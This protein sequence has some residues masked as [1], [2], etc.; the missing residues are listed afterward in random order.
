MP[1]QDHPDARHARLELTPAGWITAISLIVL[2]I[3]ATAGGV[4]LVVAPD[5]SVMHMPLSLLNGSPFA[6]YLVPG[7]IL[8]SLFGIGSLVG[9]ALVLLRL[10]FAPLVAFVIGAGQM[11]WIIVQLSIIKELSWLHPTM[12]LVG[13][14]IAVASV[15]WGAPV[16][17]SLFGRV[18]PPYETR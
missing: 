14:V 16:M 10:W 17:S 3:G 8:L 5:G 18:Q 7:L 2:G 9:A 4:S 1:T 13:L 11:I 15:I 12:F 6:D